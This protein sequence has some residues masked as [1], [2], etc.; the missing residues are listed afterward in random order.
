MGWFEHPQ[1]TYLTEFLFSSPLGDGLVPTTAEKRATN[2]PIF[3]PEWGWVGSL[4][5]DSSLTGIRYFR[6]RV[7]MGWFLNPEQPTH[8][9]KNFRPR[10]GMGWFQ[11]KSVLSAAGTRCHFRPRVGMGWFKIIPTHCTIGYQF[12]SPSGDG[13]VQSLLYHPKACFS[14]SSPSGD[15]VVL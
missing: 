8:W 11:L 9:L 13:L 1:K 7:G 6:P 2:A 10:L 12:S 3:V 4:S 15:G 5:L 14:F